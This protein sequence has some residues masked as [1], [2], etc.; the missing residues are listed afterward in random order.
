MGTGKRIVSN[1][2][3]SLFSSAGIGDLGIEYGCELPVEI[4]C[5]LISNR[6]NLIQENY[7]NACVIHGDIWENVDRIVANAR[8]KHGETCPR[9]VTLS[10]P[11][12][13]M[14]S[15]GK[16]RINKAKKQGKRPKYDPRNQL[17]LPS[18]DV[19]EQLLPEFFLI[20]NAPSMMETEI[21]I[22]DKPQKIR[23]ILEKRLGGTY[24]I[25]SFQQNFS[26]YGVPQSRNRSITIGR[27]SD[28][29]SHKIQFNA[30]QWFDIGSETETVTL[31]KAL[32]NHTRIS[33]NDPY[34][35]PL[36]H[37]PRLMTWISNIPKNSAKSAHFN[38]CLECDYPPPEYGI[39][40][41]DN[42]KCGAI[43]PRPQKDGRAI[44]GFKTSYKR[45][46]GDKPASTVT[47][48]SGCPSSDTQIH[49]SENR[50]NTI[51]EVM[52]L[53]TFLNPV[54]SRL[55]YPWEG[56]YSFEGHISKKQLTQGTNIIRNAMGEAIPP[57]AMQRMVQSVL[58]WGDLNPK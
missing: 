28:D 38:P 30:P 55:K 42:P 37:N 9:L 49:Y 24:E 47:M 6:A 51:R 25:Y 41:C 48:N 18:I 1:Y 16:G 39:V 22:E 46:D 50:T 58:N 10:P 44:K 17:I 40:E 54:I 56:K 8:R 34:H 27:Y 4:F 26:H 19:I 45:M 29:S 57:L 23:T 2:S 7:P 3:V 13:G 53:M 43:L 21:L 15:N 11:C 20:E 31:R 5:E 36:S 14:S 12:Q 32:S 35:Q 33:T 52:I